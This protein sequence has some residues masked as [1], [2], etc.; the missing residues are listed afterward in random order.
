MTG[1]RL[2]NTHLHPQPPSPS[3]LLLLFPLR[4][5]LFLLPFISD[6]LEREARKDPLGAC[7]EG[8]EEGVVRVCA[9]SSVRDA[10]SEGEVG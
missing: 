4:F 6:W 7:D 2:R 3:L 1:I 8:M 9:R 10:S 5:Y